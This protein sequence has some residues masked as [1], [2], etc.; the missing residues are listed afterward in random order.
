M[1]II[2][3]E[4]SNT[5]LVTAVIESDRGNFL[6][7]YVMDTPTKT[8]SGVLDLVFICNYSMGDV[9]NVVFATPEIAAM[10]EWAIK[11]AEGK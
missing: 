4:S 11:Q 5:I 9:Y 2:L 3:A 8:V 10:Y 7:R 1:A 6:C